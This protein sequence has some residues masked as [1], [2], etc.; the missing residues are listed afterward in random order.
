MNDSHD[1]LPYSAFEPVGGV[2]FS[3]ANAALAQSGDFGPV[4]ACDNATSG[5]RGKT[6]ERAPL[7]E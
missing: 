5:S 7:R 4:A 6:A 2:I 1:A 3:H